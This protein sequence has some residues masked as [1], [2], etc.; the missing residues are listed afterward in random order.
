MTQRLRDVQDAPTPTARAVYRA[1]H[2][3]G[4]ADI[5]IP[6]SHY[7]HDAAV[8]LHTYLEVAGR[9]DRAEVLAATHLRATPLDMKWHKQRGR[10]KEYF[11]G[12]VFDALEVPVAKAADG[13]ITTAPLLS[14][15]TP[16]M[17]AHIDRFARLLQ[18]TGDRAEAR[19]RCGLSDVQADRLD[20]GICSLAR[21]TGAV[22]WLVPE[23]QRVTTLMR[24][25]RHLNG[26][27]KLFALL[28]QSPE[29]WLR[30]LSCVWARDGHLD[31][32]DG[33]DAVLHLAD[34]Q[35]CEAARM[36]LE[37]TSINLIFK[38]GGNGSGLLLGASVVAANVRDRHNSPASACRWVFAMTWL[39]NY[40][41]ASS[42]LASSMSSV[43]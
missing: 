21:Q 31:V 9:P 6:L 16:L 4:E 17:P 43:G 37:K 20:Q 27:D 7:V 15:H 13:F 18:R 30:K 2:A 1:L 25:T 32:V 42:T 19:L 39:H 28:D 38:D 36:L 3:S 22:P 34:D 5:L 12:T 29:E 40:L 26:T 23:I 8:P 10:T 41:V 35:E 11:F 33:A 14:R 24:A